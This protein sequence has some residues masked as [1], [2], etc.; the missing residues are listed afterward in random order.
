VKKTAKG[1]ITITTKIN[2]QLQ[3]TT[4]K[5]GAAKQTA[6]AR[7]NTQGWFVYSSD[8]GVHVMTTIFDDFYQ[9]SV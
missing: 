3:L 6:A 9:F 1:N 2:G 7:K 8:S 4:A 5:K